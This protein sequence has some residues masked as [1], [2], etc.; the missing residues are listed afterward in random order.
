ARRQRQ[1][2]IRARSP[3]PPE[4]AQ[5]SQSPDA[6]EFELITHYFNPKFAAGQG[7][8]RSFRIKSNVSYPLSSAGEKPFNVS[9]WLTDE[10]GEMLEGVRSQFPIPLEPGRELTVPVLINPPEKPGVYKISVQIVQEFVGWRADCPL[11]EGQI[12]VVERLPPRSEML[13]PPHNGSFDF[14]EDLAS[15]GRAYSL[16]VEIVRREAKKNDLTVLEIA[17]GNDPQVLRFYQPNSRV[18]ACD[19]SF[20]QAQLGSLVYLHRKEVPAENF[21]FVAADVFSAPFRPGSFDI[22]VVCAAL[23]HFRDTAVALDK[24]RKLLTPRGK[25]VLL[26]EP[27]KVCAND[28][29]YIRELEN[30][31][32]E[33]QFEIA[34][35]DVMFE[36]SKLSPIYEQLDFEC[37]Y[38]AILTTNS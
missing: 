23:H 18:V 3:L 27:G 11:F 35:Y 8:Y 17:C 10:S 29:T 34:E 15:S 9:Y 24:L 5:P 38:K 33:Q 19:V 36:R 13:T 21:C 37:S 7:A 6:P 31:F 14:N 16:A 20:P 12:E 22:I 1:M 30:G 2:C 25:I 26:R 32:N 4:A 28:P